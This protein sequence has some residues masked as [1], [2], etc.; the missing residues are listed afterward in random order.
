MVRLL[1]ALAAV[2]AAAAAQAE[3]NLL[4]AANI[5]VEYQPAGASPH[6]G[7][8]V[9][10]AR[11]R[12]SWQ[13]ASD[14]PAARDQV[15][16][17]YELLVC[18]VLPDGSERHVSTSSQVW[19][20][21]SI[22]VALGCDAAS[23]SAS[24]CSTQLETDRTYAVRVRVWSGARGDPPQPRPPPATDLSAPAYFGTA[25][26]LRDSPGGSGRPTLWAAPWITG[27]PARFRAAA[28]AGLRP[29]T[30]GAASQ[31]RPSATSCGCPSRCRTS[32]SAAPACTPRPRAT[33]RCGSTASAS[34]TT[35]MSSGPG[36]RGGSG[37]CTART[38]SPQACGRVPTCSGS[39]SAGV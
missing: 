10:V 3:P 17:G 13:L 11:P 23:A 20:A 9:D 32:R 28:F 5:T 21:E 33:P 2:G 34:T 8:L 6:L 1:L 12:F 38:T 19:R 14:D 16:Q 22:H 31:R 24:G 25:L 39:G 4:R 26:G 18:E 36:H 30:D 29:H 37:C 15:Q 27:A 35:A 7:P